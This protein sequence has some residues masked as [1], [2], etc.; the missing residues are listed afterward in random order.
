M[1]EIEILLIFWLKEEILTNLIERKI[2]G[3]WILKK[4]IINFF[5]YF[6]FVFLL[7]LSYQTQHFQFSSNKIKQTMVFVKSQNTLPI[8][9]L[10]PYP[11]A[12]TITISLALGNFCVDGP[13][14]FDSFVISVWFL[15]KWMKSKEQKWKSEPW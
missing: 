11:T 8:S 7:F 4:K 2:Q 5:F 13:S 12:A 15:W 1:L 10:P 6:I 3:K 9:Q 14:G